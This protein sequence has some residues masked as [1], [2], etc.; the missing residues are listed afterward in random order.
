VLSSNPDYL[1]VLPWHF[2]KFFLGNERYAGRSLLFPLPKL[3]VER[4]PAVKD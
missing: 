3:V 1:M 4:V 2:K